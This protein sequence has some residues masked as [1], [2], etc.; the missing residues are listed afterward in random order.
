MLYEYLFVSVNIAG[1]KIKSS[2]KLINLLINFIHPKIKRTF[3]LT[4]V[5]MSLLQAVIAIDGVFKVYVI[6]NNTGF[7]NCR[8]NLIKQLVDKIFFATWGYSVSST[9][10]FIDQYTQRVGRYSESQNQQLDKYLSIATNG[11][12]GKHSKLIES[13]KNS[14]DEAIRKTGENIEEVQLDVRELNVLRN[15]GLIQKNTISDNAYTFWFSKGTLKSFQPGVPLNL[16]TFV[17]GLFG[18]IL[19]SM[20]LTGWFFLPKKMI[21]KDN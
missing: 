12:D 6:L 9:P 1:K 8:M 18:G 10:H 4:M 15:R 13:F 7:N 17:Y 20:F 14:K 3:S 21:Q 2:M 5:S 11:Y 19:F 16:W